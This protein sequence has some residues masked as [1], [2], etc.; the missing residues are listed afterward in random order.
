MELKCKKWQCCFC[1][2][3]E[4]SLLASLGG[5]TWD[6]SLEQEE[7]ETFFLEMCRLPGSLIWNAF[8]QEMTDNQGILWT[9]CL[10]MML[11]HVMHLIWEVNGMHSDLLQSSLGTMATS[12][13]AIGNDLCVVV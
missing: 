10:Y 3:K 1:Y 4:R 9:Q 8:S 5:Q 13:L 7:S 11:L 2:A 6:I 12:V